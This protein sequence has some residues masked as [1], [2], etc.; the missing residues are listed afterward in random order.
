MKLKVTLLSQSGRAHSDIQVTAD[1]TATVGDVATALAGATGAP[2][3]TNGM[4][5][6]MRV[7]D[8]GGSTPNLL[9]P[10]VSLLDS[11][12][13]SGSAIELV[14]ADEHR[15]QRGPGVA[16][17]RIV[18]GP[19]AGTEVFLPTGTSKI[20][21]SASCDVQLNDQLV[22][23]M[24]ARITIG[25]RV[26]I[27]D[28]NSANGVIVGGTRVSRVQL[29]AGDMA[30][31]G[32]TT[33]AVTLLRP[34]SSVPSLSTD[35]PFVRPP[36]VLPRVPDIKIALP[37]IPQAKRSMPFPW[38]AM[39]APLVMG[40]VLY[41]T[42]HSTTSLLFV[43]LSPILMLG[44]FIDN[45]IRSRRQFR[46]DV[47]AFEES[48]VAV[49][50][51]FV[52]AQRV[53]REALVASYPS[54][55]S[56][57]SAVSALDGLMWS[58]RAEHP[59]FLQL[60]LGIGN[61]PSCIEAE[62]PQG[63]GIPEMQHRALALREEFLLLRD[64]P[65]VADLRSCGALGLAGD[66][67]VLDG[68][69]RAIVAQAVLLHS[70]AELVVVCLTSRAGLPR[71]DWL[72]W[73]PHTSSPHSP[74]GGI[75]LSA[76]SGSA[77]VLLAAL[78]GLVQTRSVDMLRG[79]KP[80]GPLEKPEQTPPPL[81]PSILVVV[82]SPAADRGRLTRLAEQGADVGIHVLWCASSRSHL[83]GVCRTYLEISDGA[84]KAGFVRLGIMVGNLQCESVDATVAL[85]VARRLAPVVDTGAPV[86]DTSDLPRSIPVVTLLG[87]D[88]GAAT[89]DD[90]DQ[91]VG[92]W[93]ENGSLL[94]RHGSPV[95]LERPGDLTALVG[96]DGSAPFAIDLRSQGPHALVGGTTGAGKSEFLQAWVLGLA[97]QYS[98]DRVTFLF[99]DY[100]GG[101]AFSECVKL[102]HSVGLVTD[103]STHLVRRAL[104]SLR[105]ELRHREELL[106]DKGAKDL[107]ELELTGDP[108]CPPSLI[109]VV[110]EFAALAS[111]VPEFV[112]GVVDVAQRGR[113][114]GLHLILAT[115]RPAGVIKDN[116]RANT[117]LRVA[118]RMADEHDSSDVLGDKM[119]AHFDPSVPGRGAAKTGPGR[120][121]TFQSA[122]PGSRT[123]TVPVAP[124]IDVVELGFGVTERW[125]V[126]EKAAVS[127]GQLKDI[128]RVVTAVSKAAARAEVPTPRKPWLESLADTYNLEK[129]PQRS[130]EALVLGVIDDPDRQAQ[131]PEFFYPDTD[132]NI[133]FYGAS[134]SGK[135]TALC[136]LAVAASITPRSAGAQVY[137]IDFASGTLSMLEP[138][139]HVG[140][141]ISGD[142]DERVARLMRRLTQIVDQRRERFKAVR[143]A[144]LQ[145][146][147]RH[148]G[149]EGEQRI[150]LLVDGFGTFRAEYE[151]SSDRL[152]IYNAFQQLL[153]EGRS[154]GVHVAMTADRAAA[155][156]TGI[157]A[158][159]LR[160]VVLRQVDEDAYTY[161]GVPRD[162]LTPNSKPGRAMQTD[163]PQELQ[164]AILGDGV[165][166]A[167]QSRAIDELA[168]ENAL[169]VKA[170]AETVRSLPSE[171][172][173]GQLP[174]TVQGLP[175][176]G[177]ADD[178][179]AAVGF[180]PVGTILVAGPAQSGRT[181]ALRW[182]AESVR[183]TQP[184][185]RMVHLSVRRTPLSGLPLWTLCSVGAEPAVAVVGKVKELLEAAGSEPVTKF[186]IVVEG[187]PEFLSTPAEVPLLEVVKLAR[188]NGHLVIAEGETSTWSSQWQ[189]NDI[190]N[191]RV[192][193]LLQPDQ[194]DG[195]TLLRTPLPRVRRN[196]FPPGRGIWV[197]S[198]RTRKVQIP[199]VD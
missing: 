101:S 139:P 195:D 159:F 128:E 23:K 9:S 90:A 145:E 73:L 126:P 117:N 140:A 83:P 188:L 51:E 8:V 62:A 34:E 177:I 133:L 197:R 152:A 15:A 78:E 10:R 198:G 155:V 68:I 39:I 13:R 45:R 66:R 104:R 129:L 131:Y 175:V 119:A 180:D 113:S 7:T 63:R 1:A 185:A 166:M 162:V 114:L 93:R 115:Q 118:L 132:G 20:G 191:G 146:F 116:L 61:T 99:V 37:E 32:G 124:P 84:N 135:S 52:A 178:T 173:P 167:A 53:E 181:N 30:T 75:H 29:G 82:D 136:S 123:P 69:A 36:Q 164:L 174:A 103:L 85:S 105:A 56:C 127:K 60:R 157:A 40:S 156:P 65:V 130:D 46:A 149:N 161:L 33:I 107:I 143:A 27:V 154:V 190:R 109:I 182:L 95:P 199:L 17:L 38:I 94:N 148:P 6:S 43:G 108:D 150:L 153:G 64:A 184:T 141:V 12:I 110:D 97:H 88:S 86:A 26:E 170:R 67:A 24:H 35:I 96:H 50:G 59:Q 28:E 81:I 87:G 189:L 186:V 106:H 160:K 44:T 169:R 183:R 55:E 31:L 172:A 77:S 5:H 120:I 196:D 187:I 138:M 165:S 168:A 22:S 14:V 74:L 70:P 49:R 54:T 79:S 11:G 121:T 134:G 47:E 193:L 142:D 80:R 137:A 3:A 158:T 42:T 100:K 122:F 18:S 98:P 179:L 16:V 25:D 102:P 58:R 76:D 21:R 147:R 72:Q 151:S 92:R 19:D 194:G 4:N 57:V 125:R 71:W 112:D 41:L 91:I 2:P 171:V 192:G 176:L 89:V 48:L 144:T 111:E 163:K